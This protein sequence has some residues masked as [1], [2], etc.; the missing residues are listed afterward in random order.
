MR[1]WIS[2][3]PPYPQSSQSRYGL[4][5]VPKDLLPCFVSLFLDVKRRQLIDR[6]PLITLIIKATREIESK[7]GLVIDFENDGI[8]AKIE[9][10]VQTLESR[11]ES[12]SNCRKLMNTSRYLILI[13][14]Y[15][16]KFGFLAKKR[17]S[18]GTLCLHHISVFRKQTKSSHTYGCFTLTNFS[19]P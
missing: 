9:S 2:Y 3:S 13:E 11:T 1:Y 12:V 14:L 5:A 19:F 7:E 15:D 8:W 6:N 17:S 16:D 10:L 4:S 18:K